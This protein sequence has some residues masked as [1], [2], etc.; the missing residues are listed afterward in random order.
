MNYKIRQ[1]YEIEME[2][3]EEFLYEVIF[4][5]EGIDKPS[6]DIIK[7]P[8]L[9]I[10]IK[11]F[12]TQRGDYYLVAEVE[13]QI[14]GA[15]WSRIINDY[16]YIDDETPSLS[17]SLHKEYRGQGIGTELMKQLLKLLKSEGFRK[18]SLSVQK[19]N[20]ASKMY[21]KLGFK[22]FRENDEEFVMNLVL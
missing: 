11:D 5:P 22:V 2:V 18:V 21:E 1:I 15:A 20:Y 16:G 7:A 6:R 3:L 9:Q 8:E 12:G 10:Y 17:I 19:A 14:I 4:I 13:N